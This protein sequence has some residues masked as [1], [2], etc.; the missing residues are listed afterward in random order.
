VLL[1]E[2]GGVLKPER[3]TKLTHQSGWGKKPGRGGKKKG[4]QEK[5]PK[6][7][8]PL[9]KPGGLSNPLRGDYPQYRKNE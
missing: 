6:K 5:F 1:C 8:E 4:L 3:K 7:E 9:K 2:K